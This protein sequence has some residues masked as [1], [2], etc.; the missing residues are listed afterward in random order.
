MSRKTSAGAVER[1]RRILTTSLASGAF[2]T[3]KPRTKSAFS[4]RHRACED[5]RRGPSSHLGE[6]SNGPKASRPGSP[7]GSRAREPRRRLRIPIA[8]FEHHEHQHGYSDHRDAL[9]PTDERGAGTR[10]SVFAEQLCYVHSTRSRGEDA[11]NKT[12]S[13]TVAVAALVVCLSA[14]RAADACT[15]VMEPDP[16]HSQIRS[17]V[18]RDLKAADA[19]FTAE[20]VAI[21]ILGATLKVEKVWKGTI[22]DQVRMRHVT[23]TATGEIAHNSCDV[24]FTAGQRYIVFAIAAPGGVMVAHHCGSTAPLDSASK[25]LQILGPPLESREDRKGPAGEE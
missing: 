22:G 24:D 11:V 1:F 5:L 9:I 12:S 7:A 13:M 10:T 20:A 18:L 19:V 21:D 23:V 6:N 25:T 8:L 15:C 14:A 16:S 3:A 2:W 4:G 17:D